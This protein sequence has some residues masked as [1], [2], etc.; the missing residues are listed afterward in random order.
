MEK[1]QNNYL[2]TCAMWIHKDG[3]MHVASHAGWF[4]LIFLFFNIFF[5]AYCFVQSNEKASTLNLFAY[6]SWMLDYIFDFS[7]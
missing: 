5:T 7:H 2:S 3:T 6:F 4:T 1:K